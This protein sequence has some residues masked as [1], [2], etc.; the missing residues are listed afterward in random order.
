V[1]LFFTIKPAFKTGSYLTRPVNSNEGLGVAHLNVRGPIG[2]RENSCP[3]RNLA[4]FARPPA[5]DAKT[6]KVLQA[7]GFTHR[8]ENAKQ[9]G[10][11]KVREISGSIAKTL[12][13]SWAHASQTFGCEQLHLQ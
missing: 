10:F 3:A 13:T 6:C 8:V 7:Q 5:V 9:V 11:V 1:V 2:V 4:K 12:E